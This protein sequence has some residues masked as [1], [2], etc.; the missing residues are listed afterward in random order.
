LETFRKRQ[1]EFFGHATRGNGLEKLVVTGK[2]EG[3]RARGKQ[4][5]NYLVSLGTC[6]PNINITPLELAYDQGN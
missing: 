6:W 2:I 1:L 5:M 4:T 3:T